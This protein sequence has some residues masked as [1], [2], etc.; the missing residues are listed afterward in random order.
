M[1]TE[2]IE[3]LLKRESCIRIQKWW[4]D[5]YRSKYLECPVCY[6]SGVEFVNPYYCEHNICIGCH[7]AWSQRR[8]G[9]PLCRANLIPVAPV[10]PVAPVDLNQENNI[11]DDNIPGDANQENNINDNI[12]RILDEEYN[13]QNMDINNNQ[14]MDINNNQNMDINNNQNMNINNINN[15][16]NNRINYIYDLFERYRNRIPNEDAQIDFVRDLLDNYINNA[17]NINNIW[18]I[19]RDIFINRNINFIR[20]LWDNYNNIINPGD[21]DNRNHIYRLLN[22]FLNYVRDNNNM[23]IGHNNI[24]NFIVNNLDNNMIDYIRNN[25]DNVNNDNIINYIRNNIDNNINDNYLNYINN[26]HF[27]NVNYIH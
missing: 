24:V 5:I 2:R 16:L 10:A 23:F 19:R 20:E 26:I 25:I 27:N 18:Y 13:N 6:L 4:K 3:F 22:L 1:Y 12:Q 21:N 15:Y 17:D 8:G 7:N 9:C 14:N 11:N